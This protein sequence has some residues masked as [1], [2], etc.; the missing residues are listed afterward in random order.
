MFSVVLAFVLYHIWSLIVPVFAVVRCQCCLC[1]C[2]H[3]GFHQRQAVPYIGALLAILI[4][5]MLCGKQGDV[6][7]AE[8]AISLLGV[9]GYRS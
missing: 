7:A 9:G 1:C 6:H 3:H 2:T 4:I 5:I 8:L